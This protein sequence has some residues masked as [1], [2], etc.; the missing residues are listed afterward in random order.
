M[1]V[2]AGSGAWRPRSCLST[3]PSSSRCRR[4]TGCGGAATAGWA[5]RTCSPCPSST[6]SFQRGG[7]LLLFT[8]PLLSFPRDEASEQ[9]E[10]EFV[11][12]LLAVAA[13]TKHC[14]SFSP[15][16]WRQRRVQTSVRCSV[17]PPP[18]GAPQ[19]CGAHHPAGLA[20][21]AHHGSPKRQVRE[22]LPVRR[23]MPRLTAAHSVSVG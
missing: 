17:R 5:A 9:L 8:V 21:S 15:T 12:Q 22:S 19:I 10:L 23:T 7:L 1:A 16:L 20:T 6:L 3:S 11:R 2:R 14:R 13:S 18:S 4:S